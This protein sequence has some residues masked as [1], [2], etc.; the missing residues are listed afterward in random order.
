MTNKKKVK[1]YK[2]G[3]KCH[4]KKDC[5]VLKQNPDPQGNVTNTSDDGSVLVCEVATTNEGRSKL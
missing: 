2:C 5:W 1:C 3:K 4:Y